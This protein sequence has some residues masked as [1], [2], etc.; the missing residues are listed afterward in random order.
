MSGGKLV[1]LAGGLGGARVAAAG[2]TVTTGLRELPHRA[3][4]AP[5]LRYLPGA[6]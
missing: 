4:S 6:A 5:W 3:K 1:S 2:S